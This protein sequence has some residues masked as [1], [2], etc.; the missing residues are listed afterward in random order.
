[1]CLGSSQSQAYVLLKPSLFAANKEPEDAPTAARDDK[2]SLEAALGATP[3]AQTDSAEA[4]AATTVSAPTSADFVLPTVADFKKGKK[5]KK[6]VPLEKR[7]AKHYRCVS[8]EGRRSTTGL[9]TVSLHRCQ[10]LAIAAR[11]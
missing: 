8:G 1:M 2:M 9:L 10:G 7:R 4:T 5:V 3:G 11:G 6:V